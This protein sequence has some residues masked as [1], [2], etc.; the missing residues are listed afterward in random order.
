[1]VGTPVAVGRHSGG[2]KLGPSS[3]HI[4]IELQKYPDLEPQDRPDER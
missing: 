3:M 1:M 2:K 4:A